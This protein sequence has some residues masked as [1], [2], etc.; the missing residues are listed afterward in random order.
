MKLWKAENL[1]F[2]LMFRGDV[3]WF[4]WNFREDFLIS[5]KKTIWT[6]FISVIN[7]GGDEMMRQGRCDDKSIFQGD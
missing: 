6:T 3:I 2:Y 1:I 5:Q 4:M 7:I